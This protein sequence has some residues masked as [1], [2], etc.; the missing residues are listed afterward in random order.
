MSPHSRRRDFRKNEEGVRENRSGK[1]ETSKLYKLPGRPLP[2][3]GKLPRNLDVSLA[4]LHAQVN[5]RSG[6]QSQTRDAIKMV[7]TSVLNIWKEIL[8]PDVVSELHNV[9]KKVKG[10]IES[11]KASMKSE[12]P[13][14]RFL[15]NKLISNR[16]NLFDISL[17]KAEIAEED[18]IFLED[19]KSKRLLSRGVS[20]SSSLA[21]ASSMEPLLVDGDGDMGSISATDIS[22]SDDGDRNNIS[23]DDDEEEE[24]EFPTIDSGDKLEGEENCPINAQIPRELF[25]A[26]KVLQ[27]NLA[28]VAD[29]G[30]IS[31]RIIS[32]ITNVFVSGGGLSVM[33]TYNL[34]MRE[35]EGALEDLISEIKE[36]QV[37][38]LGCDERKDLSHHGNSSY[39]VVEHNSVVLYCS[40][41][42]EYVLGSFS[43]ED[44]TGVKLAEGTF[45]Y[46]QERSINLDDLTAIISDGCA[47]M[48]GHLHGFQAEFEK[49]LGRPLQRLFCYFHHTE[50]SFGAMFRLYDGETAG[51]G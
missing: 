29:R 23:K 11:E 6:Y 50:K 40:D 42:S 21:Q 12:R 49:L 20:S 24:D 41:G 47:K 37:I 9:M 3:N 1:V 26:D 4:V 48:K 44:G 39:K 32:D 7:S 13:A 8:S 2:R 5:T 25:L 27:R 33:G 43:P 28:E 36:K 14:T 34:R 51:N 18:K 38:C 22:N 31:H 45:K 10:L 35:R 19:Q 30:N 15:R 17:T 46:L 16:N